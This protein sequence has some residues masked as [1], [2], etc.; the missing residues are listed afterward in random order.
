DWF[1]KTT[2]NI[3][4]SI[5]P[6]DPVQPAGTTFANIPGM[7]INNTG[8]EIDLEYRKRITGNLSLGIGGNATFMKNNVTGSPY[9]VIFAGSAT[10]LGL[11]SATLNGYINGIPIASF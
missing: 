10:G 8:I 11:T 7:E 5:P 6:Q 2:N 3:L 1:D 9:Q 4:L